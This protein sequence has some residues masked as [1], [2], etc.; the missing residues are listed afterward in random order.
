MEDPCKTDKPARQLCIKLNLDTDEAM[1][2]LS[3]IRAELE[4]IKKLSEELGI[5]KQIQ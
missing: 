2:K 5:T 1:K 3:A 4:G